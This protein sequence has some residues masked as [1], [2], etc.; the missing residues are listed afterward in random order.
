M[1]RLLRVHLIALLIEQFASGKHFEGS[2][3]IEDMVSRVYR[4]GVRS[5]EKIVAV[6]DG[7][8]VFLVIKWRYQA[9][10][11][12]KNKGHIFKI[13]GDRLL[14]GTGK[15]TIFGTNSGM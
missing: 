11:F 2:E 5:A 4:R 10:H 14:I 13:N 7:V 1:Y 15:Q 6:Y 9:L 12:R 3:R 8:A